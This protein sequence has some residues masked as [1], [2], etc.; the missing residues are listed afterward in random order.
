M[1]KESYRKFVQAT[2]YIG[3]LKKDN[4]RECMGSVLNG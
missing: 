3:R 1:Q 2:K 4:E